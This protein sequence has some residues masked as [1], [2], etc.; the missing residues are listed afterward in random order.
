MKHFS[1]N[2]IPILEPNVKLPGLHF[3]E[4]LVHSKRLLNLFFE[5]FPFFLSFFLHYAAYIIH[6]ICYCPNTVKHARR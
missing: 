5:L 3:P 1:E 6:E 2:A 4:P